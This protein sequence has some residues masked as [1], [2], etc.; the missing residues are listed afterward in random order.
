MLLLGVL[1]ATILT[2]P[3]LV[4]V[5]GVLVVGLQFLLFFLNDNL[6]YAVAIHE[7]LLSVCVD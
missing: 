1:L 3:L 2:F 7:I 4:Y 6:H 5:I